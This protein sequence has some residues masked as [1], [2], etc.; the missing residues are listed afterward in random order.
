MG[1]D[2]LRQ[3]DYYLFLL[4]YLLTLLTYLLIYYSIVTN[5]QMQEYRDT[6]LNGAVGQMYQ[7]MASRHRVRYPCI[8]VRLVCCLFVGVVRRGV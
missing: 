2:P 1:V 5:T 7:E 6:T 3:T 4:T 8:Q